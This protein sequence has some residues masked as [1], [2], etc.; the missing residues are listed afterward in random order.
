MG[1]YEGKF[2]EDRETIESI[3]RRHAFTKE[4]D[5]RVYCNLNTEILKQYSLPKD[6]VCIYKDQEN[7]R[8]MRLEFQI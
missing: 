1:Q 2:Y 6:E 8:C 3:C 5:R 7:G 4:K